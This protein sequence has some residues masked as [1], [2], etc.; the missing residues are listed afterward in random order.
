MISSDLDDL[1]D[2][3]DPETK[4]LYVLV[5]TQNHSGLPYLSLETDSIVVNSE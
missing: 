3:L 1:M 2:Y 5:G 4:T